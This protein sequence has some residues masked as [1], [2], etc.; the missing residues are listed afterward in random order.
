LTLQLKFK[1]GVFDVFAVFFLVL[2]TLPNTSEYTA[3]T[4][5]MYATTPTNTP[6]TANTSLFK[7]T[8]EIKIRLSCQGEPLTIRAVIFFSA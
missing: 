8:A 5:R 3:N 6:K 2:S 1:I 4:A 7:F